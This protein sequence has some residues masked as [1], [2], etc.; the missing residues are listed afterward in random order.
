[1]NQLVKAVAAALIAGLLSTVTG[2]SSIPGHALTEG[3]T[4]N[5][6]SSFNPGMGNWG[7]NDNNQNG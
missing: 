4:N 7:W 5:E 2:C 3:Q 6:F 1:M